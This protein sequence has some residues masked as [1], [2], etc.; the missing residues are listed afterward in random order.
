[1]TALPPPCPAPPWP[2]TLLDHVRDLTRAKGHSEVTAR[3]FV[4]WNRAFI[5]FHGKRHPRKWAGGWCAFAAAPLK[6]GSRPGPAAAKAWHT[7]HFGLGGL[8]GL[9]WIGATG[10]GLTELAELMELRKFSL[11]RL[12]YYVATFSPR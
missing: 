2:L 4:D 3:S 12:G 10:V 7:H 6:A 5:L 1:M 9:V 8:P 11:G